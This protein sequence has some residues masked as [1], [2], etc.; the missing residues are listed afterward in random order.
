MANRVKAEEIDEDHNDAQERKLA[1]LGSVI[2]NLM[3]R[4]HDGHIGKVF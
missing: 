2:F 3:D 1:G 4:H